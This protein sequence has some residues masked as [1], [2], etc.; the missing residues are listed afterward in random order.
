MAKL[1]ISE[2]FVRRVVKYLRAVSQPRRVRSLTE[3]EC[4]DALEMAHRLEQRL[5]N[6]EARLRARGV[7][8]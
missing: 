1:T 6:L 8:E 4:E 5:D 2:T 3:A 7:R